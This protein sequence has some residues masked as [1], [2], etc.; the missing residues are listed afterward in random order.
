MNAIEVIVQ[1]VRLEADRIH[2][3]ELRAIDGA[4]L[5]AF[6]AGAHV[7]VHLPNGL[8][9]SYSLANPQ[10][11]SQRYQ[12]AVNKE[13]AGRGGSAALHECVHVGER[14]RIGAPR[15]HFP[16]DEVAPHSVLVAGGIGITP[17]RSMVARLRALGRPWTLLYAGRQRAGM[18]YL[19]EFAALRQWGDDVRLHVDTEAGGPPDLRALIEAAPPGAHFYCC[20]PRAMLD[21]FASATADVAPERVH[22]EHF[23]AVDAPALDGGFTVELARSGQRLR[24]AKGC[25]ILDTL[26]DAGVQVPFSC[27]EGI[28]ASCETRVLSGVPDHRDAILSKAERDANDRI[29]VCCSGAKSATLVLDL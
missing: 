8:V 25:T 10:D 5:P 24:V 28:C 22:V 17:I 21:A 9:R 20:G 29:M 3:Y 18:A 6:T 1:A 27:M 11:E 2:S 12:I 19:D 16:L 14:L 4:P 15:N 26:L 23:A 13:T 7:D